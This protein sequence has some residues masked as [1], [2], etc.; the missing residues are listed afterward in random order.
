MYEPSYITYWV[1]S[2]ICIFSMKYAPIVVGV[3]K[4]YI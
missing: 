2:N 1:F 4:H 3:K